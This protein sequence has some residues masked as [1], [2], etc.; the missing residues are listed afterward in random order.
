MTSLS[1][2]VHQVLKNEPPRPP[3]T[4]PQERTIIVRPPQRPTR[5]DVDE[6]A[7]FN[8]RFIE[9]LPQRPWLRDVRIALERD[10]C[11]A[12]RCTPRSVARSELPALPHPRCT[13]QHGCACWYEATR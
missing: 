10:A 11:L 1:R 8:A 13:R 12:C 3:T 5:G 4:E 6:A 9:Q 2:L 7:A